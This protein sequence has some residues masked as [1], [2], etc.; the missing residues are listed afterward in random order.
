MLHF[1]DESF[2]DYPLIRL[3]DLFQYLLSSWRK[4][5]TFRGLEQLVICIHQ[6]KYIIRV[7]GFITCMLV[8]SLYSDMAGRFNSIFGFKFCHTTTYQNCNLLIETSQKIRYC[9]RIIKIYYVAII[10][11]KNFALPKFPT[12]FVFWGEHMSVI[13]FIHFLVILLFFNPSFISKIHLSL[14]DMLYEHVQPNIIKDIKSTKPH[15]QKRN[16]KKKYKYFSI[17]STFKMK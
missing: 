9:S 11:I 1:A 10:S 8:I 15:T 14:A 17:T 4:Y 12:P 13:L 3:E 2:L 7:Y 16:I 6:T 5:V